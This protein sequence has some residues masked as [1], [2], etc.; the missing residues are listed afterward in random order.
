MRH[1]KAFGW[2]SSAHNICGPDL[3]I[4]LSTG[5]ISLSH[6]QLMLQRKG[7]WD[8]T[9]G[10]QPCARPN[11]YSKIWKPSPQILCNGSHSSSPSGFT[12]GSNR[13]H[14]FDLELS[15]ALVLSDN[16]HSSPLPSIAQ[17]HIQLGQHNAE[18]KCSVNAWVSNT[19][20]I[21]T[22]NVT[23]SLPQKTICGITFE[24]KEDLRQSTALILRNV[25]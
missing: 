6:N 9:S 2:M 3:S 18:E 11:L 1:I 20:P 12:P 13:W 22:Y 15:R 8:K 23:K 17:P 25:K 19:A 21:H 10:S 5:C 7:Q 14:P 16:P 24:R 4:T